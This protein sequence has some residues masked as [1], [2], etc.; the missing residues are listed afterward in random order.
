[1]FLSQTWNKSTTDPVCECFS[2]V[3]ELNMLDSAESDLLPVL[4][5]Y[6]K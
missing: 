5:Q 1:M 6:C 2:E 3:V 4:V